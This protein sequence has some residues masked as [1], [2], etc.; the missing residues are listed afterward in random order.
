[1]NFKQVE[2]WSKYQVEG[3]R[4]CGE[5]IAQASATVLTVLKKTLPLLKPY[6]DEVWSF[7]NL[8]WVPSQNGV[9]TWETFIS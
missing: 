6:T 7:V 2:F 8:W 9:N 1:M 3:H 4:R 5:G